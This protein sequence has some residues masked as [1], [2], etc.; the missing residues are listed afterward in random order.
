MVIRRT[1]K[2]DVNDEGEWELST[3]RRM[4]GLVIKK[5]DEWGLQ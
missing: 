1:S 5:E 3:M 4:G 2:A